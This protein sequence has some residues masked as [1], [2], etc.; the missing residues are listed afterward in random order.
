MSSHVKALQVWKAL[1][2]SRSVDKSLPSL[3]GKGFNI[4]NLLLG[5]LISSPNDTV[6]YILNTDLIVDRLGTLRGKQSYQSWWLSMSVAFDP[7]CQVHFFIKQKS[8]ISFLAL[9]K[10]HK[11][12]G[13]TQNNRH[14]SSHSAGGQ[15]SEI[16][17]SRVDSCLREAL[18]KNLFHAFLLLLM[19]ASNIY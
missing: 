16:K 7:W 17:V 14:V 4:M 6:F 19:A 13:I 8:Y 10:Y 12:D 11:L 3:W 1:F 9:L 15:K 18:R 2:I 5:R